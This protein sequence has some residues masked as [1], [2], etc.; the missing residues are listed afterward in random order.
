MPDI[1]FENWAKHLFRCPRCYEASKLAIKHPDV[2][3]SPS[4][5][6][7]ACDQGKQLRV[8]IECKPS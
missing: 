4:W 2:W 7:V 8:K 6:T 5:K 3:N 1:E